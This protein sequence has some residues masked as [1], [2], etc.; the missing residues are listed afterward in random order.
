VRQRI[1]IKDSRQQGCLGVQKGAQ[2]RHS[3]NKNASKYDIR[4]ITKTRNRTG[5]LTTA[6]RGG[7]EL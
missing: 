2:N 7:K 1:N 4:G 5:M 3:G 6:I